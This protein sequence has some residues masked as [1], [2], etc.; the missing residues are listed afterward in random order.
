M[1]NHDPS[2]QL[3]HWC[4]HK[5]EGGRGLCE[6]LVWVA[7]RGLVFRDVCSSCFEVGFGVAASKHA[8]WNSCCVPRPSWAGR[9]RYEQHTTH[10]RTKLFFCALSRKLP[11]KELAVHGSHATLDGREAGF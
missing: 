10:R 6:R 8:S 3:R 1:G 2:G 7:L 9:N 4:S 11:R 5:R